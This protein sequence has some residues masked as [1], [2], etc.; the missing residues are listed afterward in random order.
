MHKLLEMLG[1]KKTNR[2]QIAM[3]GRKRNR[4]ALEGVVRKLHPRLTETGF[5]EK[6]GQKILSPEMEDIVLHQAEDNPN[7]RA[8]ASRYGFP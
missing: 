4:N 6:R 8:V 3:Q 1:G 2:N 7:N 5:F